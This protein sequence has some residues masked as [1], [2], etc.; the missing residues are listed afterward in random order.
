MK[1]RSDFVLREVAGS[2]VVLPIGDAIVNFDGI[3]SLNTSGKM[4]WNL[5]E[6]ETNTDALVELLISEYT[7]S[8]KE[9]CQDVL[10]FL[11][12]LRA[13]GCLEE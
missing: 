5:L 8:R 11:D 6:T 3:I 2:F 4:L 10:S 9:A 12:A 1:I 7:V 13:V